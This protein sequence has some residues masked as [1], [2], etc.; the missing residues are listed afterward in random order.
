[1]AEAKAKR[2]LMDILRDATREKADILAIN[3]YLPD[4]KF[5][6]AWNVEL[7][8]PNDPRREA[9][10]EDIADQVIAAISKS[11]E[12]FDNMSDDEVFI[13]FA[14]ALLIMDRSDTEKVGDAD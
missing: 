12:K 3:G 7:P 5:A 11:P 2:D 13:L 1:M 9:T 6:S 10:L 8:E 14:S 4:D